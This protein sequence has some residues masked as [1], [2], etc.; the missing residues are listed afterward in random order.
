MIRRD[1][2]IA[3]LFLTLALSTPALSTNALA[4]PVGTYDVVGVN[5]D[6]GGEYSGTVVVS[7]N[8]ETYSVV[9][10]IS[11][12]ESNGVGIGGKR[13]GNVT[14]GAGSVDDDI[15]TIGYGNQNGFGISQY[16]LQPD[17]SWKGHWAYAGGQKVSTETWTRPGGATRS[18]DLPKSPASNAMKPMGNSVA[19]P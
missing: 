4:D 7:R 12:T 18:I 15:I 10:T 2:G 6:T 1:F 11:G 9:W 17:G 14:T 3:G 5:P 8:G 13:G 19:R 16:D